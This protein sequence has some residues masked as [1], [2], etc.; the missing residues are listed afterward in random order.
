MPH[1]LAPHSTMPQV[2]VCQLIAREIHTFPN[3]TNVV[4]NQFH[5]QKEGYFLMLWD[6]P[7]MEWD[8][9]PRVKS[10]FVHALGGYTH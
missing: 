5:V 7:D 8:L 6:R 10:T 4:E 3:H 2:H 1:P 9:G